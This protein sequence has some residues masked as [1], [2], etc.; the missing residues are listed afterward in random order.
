MI[1]L[2]IL[3]LGILYIVIYGE[4][5]LCIAFFFFLQAYVILPVVSIALHL[6][7][8]KPKKKNQCLFCL[9]F[10]RR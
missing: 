1:W 9:V 2:H 6:H 7:E 5:D 8:N 10:T 3:T 4:M